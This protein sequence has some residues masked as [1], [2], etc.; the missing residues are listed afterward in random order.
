M[1][2]FI[3]IMALN[4]P[5]LRCAITFTKYLASLVCLLLL[6]EILVQNKITFWALNSLNLSEMVANELMKS[7]PKNPTQFIIA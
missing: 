3:C 7:I 5:K 6:S 2:L 1:K 4:R